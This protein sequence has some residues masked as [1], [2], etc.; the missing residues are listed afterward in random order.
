MWPFAAPSKALRDFGIL[1]IRARVGSFFS[2][3]HPFLLRRLRT[4]AR[5]STFPGLRN[6]MSAEA[7]NWLPF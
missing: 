5:S 4:Q 1:A 7:S 2:T 3:N 6:V